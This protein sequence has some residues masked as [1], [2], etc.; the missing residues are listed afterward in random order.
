MVSVVVAE[1]LP[2]S[3]TVVGLKMGV[4]ATTIEGVVV[5]LGVMVALYCPLVGAKTTW[6]I[7]LSPALIVWNAGEAPIPKSTTFA[8]CVTVVVPVVA[9]FAPAMPETDTGGP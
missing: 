7:A 6:K 9:P 1:A 2:E 4:L 3:V 5:W 8:V